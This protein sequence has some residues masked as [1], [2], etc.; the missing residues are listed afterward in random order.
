MVNNT[1]RR[2]LESLISCKPFFMVSNVVVRKNSAT[3]FLLVPC[4]GTGDIMYPYS[5]CVCVCVCVEAG[6]TFVLLCAFWKSRLELHIY[7]RQGY[8]FTGV[9]DS[10]HRG[11]ACV[12]RGYAWQ[13]ACMAGGGH[14]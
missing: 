11:G 5:D 13:G 2:T 9:C 14:A 1:F 8:V 7:R 3:R 6:S 4:Q 12:A 10:V